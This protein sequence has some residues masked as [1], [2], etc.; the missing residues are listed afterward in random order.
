MLILS[1][2]LRHAYAHD[3][4]LVLSASLC[5][6]QSYE[7]IVGDSASAAEMYALLSS[8]A[9]LPIDQGIAI[10]GSMNQKGNC[11]PL[12]ALMRKLRDF[13]TSAACKG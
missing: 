11:N 5:V 4:P 7:G 2:Y 13:L 3:K 8:L 10:T 12:A 9:E 6:E 1:G